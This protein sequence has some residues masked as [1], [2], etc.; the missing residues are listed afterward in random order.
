M[1][2][3]D[4]TVLQPDQELLSL[5]FQAYDYIDH[6]CTY[7]DTARWLT[8]RSGKYLSHQALARKWKK[9]NSEKMTKRITE[10]HKKHRDEGK[11]RQAELERNTPNSSEE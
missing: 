3:E 11:R 7:R 10:A 1:N 5:L 9:Y 4:P 6:R 8:D 2:K